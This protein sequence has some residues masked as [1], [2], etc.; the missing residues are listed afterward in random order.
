MGRGMRD[1]GRCRQETLIEHKTSL[2]PHGEK[3][4][5]ARA[6]QGTRLEAWNLL[7][8][9]GSPYLRYC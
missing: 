2:F 1:E 3:G 5:N 7:D 9:V 6:P 4:R 8:M